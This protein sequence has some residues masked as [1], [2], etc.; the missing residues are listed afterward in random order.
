MTTKLLTTITLL[1]FSVVANGQLVEGLS[2]FIKT[3]DPN[4]LDYMYF[5]GPQSCPFSAN[6]ATDVI[7]DTESE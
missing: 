6:E 4:R 2:D 3:D 5:Q 7:E 1:C